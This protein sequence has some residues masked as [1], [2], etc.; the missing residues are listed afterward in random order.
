MNI[1]RELCKKKGVK[2]Y[3]LA[4]AIGVTQPAVSDWCSNK[5]DPSDENLRKLA[6]YFGVD[7]LFILGH[8][9]YSLPVIK[10]AK[11]KTIEAKILAQGID[12]LSPDQRRQ[13]LNVV[14][15]VF[16]DH[17]ELFNGGNYDEET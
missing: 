12:K 14:R 6:E 4:Q 13:A 10:D 5:K 17:P 8:G 11:P 16:S 9:L 2:Q 7:E 1:V 3:E 15:A